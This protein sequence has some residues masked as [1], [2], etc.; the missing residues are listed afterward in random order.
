[1]NVH[2][3]LIER[4][5]AADV[6]FD[7][8]YQDIISLRLRPGTKISEADIA[9]QFGISRQPVRDAFSR[10]GNLGFLLIRPQKATEVQKFLS[11]TITS[12]RFIR[13]AIEVEVVQTAARNWDGRMTRDF[14]ANLD[15][16]AAAAET[17]DVD[18]FHKLDYEFHHLICQ[19][20]GLDF[21]F[22]AI[23]EHKAQIDRLCVLSMM[24]EDSIRGLVSDHHG[25]FEAIT[26]KDG[27]AARRVM[28][29]HLAR[30]DRTIDKVRASHPQ[31]FI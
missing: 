21:A 14:E 7:S 29:A 17:A 27:E 11:D 25:I 30:L 3:A 12:A 1:M 28:R 31:F 9:A 8:V 2:S 15:A 13:A 6:V 4:R 23:V 19:A 20:A 22:N 18:A 24:D 16:Q 10:L 26:A 5:T